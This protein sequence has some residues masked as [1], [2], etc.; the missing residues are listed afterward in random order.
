MA[1]LLSIPPLGAVDSAAA[2]PDEPE[3]TSLDTPPSL[4]PPGQRV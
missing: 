1:A 4:E 2:V 3:A